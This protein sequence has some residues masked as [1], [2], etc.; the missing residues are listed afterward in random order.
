MEE[1][2]EIFLD[3]LKENEFEIESSNM[4]QMIVSATIP[5]IQSALSI[6]YFNTHTEY[7][8]VYK[9]VNV[10][11]GKMKIS[12]ERYIHDRISK[13]LR[14]KENKIKEEFYNFKDCIK[15][16]EERYLG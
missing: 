13:I 5:S 12:D 10:C 1:E 15:N 14:E 3:L 2:L 16:I 11:K 7:K 4:L 9:N 8:I 6:T